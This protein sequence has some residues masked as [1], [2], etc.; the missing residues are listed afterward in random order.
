MRVGADGVKLGVGFLV[1]ADAGRILRWAEIVNEFGAD[2]E[3]AVSDFVFI[4]II[5]TA[6]I[7]AFSVAIVGDGGVIGLR[8]D[9]GESLGFAAVACEGEIGTI[10]LGQFVI[11]AGDYAVGCVAE[12]D[13]EGAGGVGAMSDGSVEDLPGVTT[14]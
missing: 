3:E 11:S 7:I 2:E 4:I 14:V 10:L 12:G 13:G 1:R 9:F 8:E 5:I 6:F